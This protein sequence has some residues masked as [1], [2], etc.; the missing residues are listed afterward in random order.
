MQQWETIQVRVEITPALM[1]LFLQEK[2]DE[3][4]KAGYRAEVDQ[5]MADGWEITN[6]VP[7]IEGAEVKGHLYTLRRAV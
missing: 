1:S 6:L 5:L 7:I 3:M 2:Y 4:K